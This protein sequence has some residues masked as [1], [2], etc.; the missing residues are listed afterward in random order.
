MQLFLHLVLVAGALA[1]L[2]ECLHDLIDQPDVLLVD[3]EAEQPSGGACRAAA[4][5]VQQ[6]EGLRHEVVLGLVVLV[7]QQV[8]QGSVVVLTEQLEEP[9]MGCMTLFQTISTL[10]QDGLHDCHLGGQLL[11]LLLLPRLLDLL[12]QQILEAWCQGS[13]PCSLLETH[14]SPPGSKEKEKED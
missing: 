4:D 3:V 1:V 10:P 2:R 9:R 6:D 11:L 12:S 7:P 5:T 14:T 8:L 13:Q